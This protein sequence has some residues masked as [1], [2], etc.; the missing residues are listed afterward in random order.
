MPPAALPLTNPRDVADLK[1][2]VS[3]P[4]VQSSPPPT[5]VKPVTKS[6]ELAVLAALLARPN[7]RGSAALLSGKAKMSTSRVTEV[8]EHLA[9][10][11][12]VVPPEEGQHIWS[13]A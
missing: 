4:P 3:A 13:R 1:A 10:R 11:N 12:L 2:I 9:E 7:G 8:L 5:K 6:D